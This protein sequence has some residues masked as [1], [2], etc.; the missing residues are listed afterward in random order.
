[1]T[2][3]WKLNIGYKKTLSLEA[4]KSDLVYLGSALLF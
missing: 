3:S 1:V 4:F 2:D